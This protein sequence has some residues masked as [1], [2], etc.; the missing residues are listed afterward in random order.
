MDAILRLPPG[1]PPHQAAPLEPVPHAV[2]CEWP[3]GTFVENLA[4]LPDRSFAISVLSEAR[5]DR[6]TLAGERRTLIQLPAPPTGLAV[7]HGVLYAA[8]GEPGHTGAALWAI[9]PRTGAGGPAVALTEAMFLNGMTPF[10]AASA[11]A[12]LVA[13]SALG[14]L[15]LV[16]VQAKTVTRWFS[17][18][19][20]APA[21]DVPMLPGANGL[22]VF[23]RHVWVT[24]NGRALLMRVAVAPDGSAGAA[25]VFAES[26][27][28]DDMAFD[29]DGRL[30]IATHLGHSLDRIDTSL[31]GS[32]RLGL[33]GVAQGMAGSTACAF[34]PVEDA[35]RPGTAASHDQALYVTTTGGI[36]LPPGGALQT[37]KLVRLDV[38]AQGYPLTEE[39][40]T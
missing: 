25:E 10:T 17:D 21:P 33:A 1:L 35:S 20:L 11:N 8:V 14:C 18:E 36:L 7:L 38:G 39:V 6:V 27:R 34:G 22:K 3:A 16:D 15:W 40:N 12:L 19:R 23:G 26:L 31:R 13:D 29:L 28:G 5:I 37:A 4:L 9:D 2:V 30:Y 24:S 32:G